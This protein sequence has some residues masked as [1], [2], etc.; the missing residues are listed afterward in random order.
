[1]APAKKL[2]GPLGDNKDLTSIQMDVRDTKII[3]VHM[4]YMSDLIQVGFRI[5]FY[6]TSEIYL[7]RAITPT[8]SRLLDL[9]N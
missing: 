4:G 6:I 2:I 9:K 7:F 1:M 3:P 8:R 5:V